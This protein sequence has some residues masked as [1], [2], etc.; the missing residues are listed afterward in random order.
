MYLTVYNIKYNLQFTILYKQKC[1]QNPTLLTYSY[2]ELY[3]MLNRLSY[4]HLI[5]G[6]LIQHFQLGF[7][8]FYFLTCIPYVPASHFFL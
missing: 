8:L 1:W 3:I 5:L 7:I 2:L 6:H 4:L